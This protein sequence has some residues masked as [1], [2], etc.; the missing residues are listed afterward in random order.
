M[1]KKKATQKKAKAKKKVIDAPIKEEPVVTIPV[2]KK[3]TTPIKG[4]S[5][6]KQVKGRLKASI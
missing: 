4:S 3:K 6:Q 5:Y 1:A 2:E